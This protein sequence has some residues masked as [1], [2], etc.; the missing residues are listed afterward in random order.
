MI[1]KVMK[2]HTVWCVFQSPASD[3][4]KVLAT[5]AGQVTADNYDEVEMDMDS[6]PAS[7]GTVGRYTRKTLLRLGKKSRVRF[8]FDGE[9]M[10]NYLQNHSV[11][12]VRGC[13]TCVWF[14][15]H[16]S[17]VWKYCQM[18][19]FIIIRIYCPTN[20][21]WRYFWKVAHVC[22][23]SWLLGFWGGWSVTVYCIVAH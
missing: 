10:P 20:L 13:K 18:H 8:K 2:Y 7:P 17:A 19:D 12:W 22:F 3:K 23:F 1:N 11:M 6:N 5:A 21:E 15:S 16:T 14:V 4:G 9:L